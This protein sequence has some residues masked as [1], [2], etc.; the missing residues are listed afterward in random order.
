M[1]LTNFVNN[2]TV[3]DQVWL[4]KVDVLLET[5]FAES[6][7]PLAARQALGLAVDTYTTGAL[8]IVTID[9][10]EVT[11]GL[12][13][14]NIDFGFTAVTSDAT[15]V[16]K[17]QVSGSAIDANGYTYTFNE[18]V[19][20]GYSTATPFNFTSVATTGKVK[21]RIAHAATN[22]DTITVKWWARKRA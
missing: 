16:K 11:H 7:T 5:V 19:A 22:G 3:I 4:N 18:P 15:F 6:A 20:N 8:N 2:V 21:I 1:A 12:G 14:D 17:L 10:R 13:T 9:E